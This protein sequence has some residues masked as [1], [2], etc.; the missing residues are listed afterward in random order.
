MDDTTFAILSI[1]FGSLSI[2]FSFGLILSLNKKK[3]TYARIMRHIVISESIL[4]FCLLMLV[5]EKF[6][7]MWRNIMCDFMN[8]LIFNNLSP[9]SCLGINVFNY[10]AYYGLQSF[11]N[12]LSVFICLEM[13]LILKNPIS[14]MTKRVIYYFIIS[15]VT[16][17]VVFSLALFDR[18]RFRDKQDL[19][20]KVEIPMYIKLIQNYQLCHI[21][22]VILYGSSVLCLHICQI[23]YRE[24]NYVKLEKLV[25]YQTFPLCFYEHILSNYDKD[26]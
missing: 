22:D 3:S 14:Q 11:S 21:W 4:I 24:I 13:I 19:F 7:E 17:I 1:V 15:T 23:L 16:G 25:C 18:T 10:S 6:S 12:L 5:V 2:F 20:N 26:K 8:I 9:E